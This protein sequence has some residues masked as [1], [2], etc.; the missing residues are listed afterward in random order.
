VADAR[1][2]YRRAGTGSLAAALLAV[3]TVLTAQQPAHAA[4]E[5]QLSTD[6]VSWSS[7]LDGPVFASISRLV[8]GDSERATIYVRNGGQS[9]A[10]L[11][12]TL[13]DVIV[14][15]A[16]LADAITVAVA[17]GNGTAVPTALAAA[18]PCIVVAEARAVRPGGIVALDA[19][20]AVGALSGIDGQDATA[21]F[22]VTVALSQ[23]I[24]VGV[25]PTDCD[26]I[27]A[28]VASVA[29][30]A[31]FVPVD[32]ASTGRGL[33]DIVIERTTAFLTPNSGDAVVGWRILIIP[34]A[35]V[36]GGGLVNL[37]ARRRRHVAGQKLASAGEDGLR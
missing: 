1:R 37:E 34:A 16:L 31:P 5:L 27:G 28:G 24:P 32:A 35:L 9:D 14:S 4:G 30:V 11:R 7:G 25:A 33:D 18:R 21:S 20:L 17:T 19:A 15:D 29:A 8:P 36:A 6:G 3:L 2:S 22:S 26:P 13:D 23:S 10:N 12:V